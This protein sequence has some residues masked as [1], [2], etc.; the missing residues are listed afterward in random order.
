[1]KID[2]RGEICPY[3]MMKTAEAL[4]KL[5]GDESLEVLTDHAPALGTIPWE[6]AKNGYETTIEGAADSEWRLT[7]R[8]FEKEAKPQELLANLQEQLAA[9]NVSE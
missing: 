7:L 2:V 8:K 5:D 1:M 6:A 3:P 4:K 9:L